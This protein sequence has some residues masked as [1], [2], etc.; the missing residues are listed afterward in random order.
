GA[1]AN[2]G[3][4]NPL[5]VTNQL[6][7][8]DLV[9]RF[10]NS[11]EMI[12]KPIDWFSVTVRSGI[13]YFTDRQLNY[14]PYFSTDANTG[15]YS[16]QEYS[17]MQFNLD[18]FGRAE[19]ALGEHF[20]ANL[21]VGYNYN[22]LNTSSLGGSSINFTIPNGPQ[23]LNNTTPANLSVNDAFLRT[24]TNAGYASAGVSLYDQVFV[25]GSGR[26]EAASTFGAANSSFFYPSADIA[27]QF[28]R[29]HLFDNSKVFSFGKLRASYGVVG[30]QPQ[31]YQTT[32]NFVSGT[33]TESF[34]NPYLDPG[35]YG[36]GSYVQSGN[37]GNANLKP[38]RKQEVEMGADL[39]FFDNRIQFSATYYRNKTID[40]L[41]NI[42]Q[43]SSTGY[44]FLYANAGVIQNR[45]V[46]LDLSYAL[47]RKKDFSLNVD[48]NWTRNKN[49]VVNLNGA[50]SIVLGGASGVSSRAVE[51]YALGVLYSIPWLRD[52]KGN[53]V[54]DANGFPK[55][56]VT[57]AVIGDPNPDWRGGIGVT[58]KYKQFSLN[59]L[60]ERSQG[61]KVIDG[62]EAVLLDYGTSKTTEKESTASTALKRYDGST[63]ASGTTFRGSIHDFGAGNVALDQSWYTGPGGWFGNVGEQFV[64]DA[65]WTRMR[66][67]TLA[68]TFTGAALKKRLGV[69][70]IILEVSGR[71]LF[72]I[73]N[74]NGFD[75]DTNVSGSTSGRGVVYFDNPPTRSYLFTARI[76]L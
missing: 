55:P 75:P 42:P 35:L 23:D 51:G 54:L 45:G 71:N 3:F 62:T 29:L 72:L 4:N 28:S 66:E 61:G 26:V 7:N 36:T 37:K 50:G 2:P 73:S 67:L 12:I 19:K 58:V 46:E 76:N 30:I 17:E 68:Y 32:T 31:A 8:K 6:Q 25:N 16:R 13:D 40:A 38:E 74:V 21:L 52:N 64:K 57:S 22:A 14:A 49:K 24:R 11:A 60:L 1:S 18:V 70:S 43:A 20:S 5:W 44:N 39:R 27:W 63:I 48:V 41:I 10:I 59:A 33:Y 69:S 53:I 9:N 47:L 15:S 34:W 65:T 56:D